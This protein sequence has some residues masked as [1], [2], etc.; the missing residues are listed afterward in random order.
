MDEKRT[1][2]LQN[3]DGSW[4][5]ITKTINPLICTIEYDY[6]PKFLSKEEAEESDHSICIFLPGCL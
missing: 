5:Y 2:V 1:P 3:K 6:S 4:S